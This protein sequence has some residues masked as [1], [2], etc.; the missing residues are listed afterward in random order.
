MSGNWLAAPLLWF[1]M[2]YA[3]TSDRAPT[4]APVR[5]PVL[6]R[7]T[8]APVSWSASRPEAATVGTRHSAGPVALLPGGAEP[9]KAPQGEDEGAGPC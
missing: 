4:P 3:L 9:A 2:A 7:P 1:V 6:R 5:G 8:P